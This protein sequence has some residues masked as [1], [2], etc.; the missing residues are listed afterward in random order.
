[1]MLPQKGD[2]GGVVMVDVFL[3]CLGS[4]GLW[5]GFCV[6]FKLLQLGG[7]G[8]GRGGCLCMCV[9]HT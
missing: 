9:I 1:M 7:G 6:W 4:V 8:G 3:S 5:V 2:W